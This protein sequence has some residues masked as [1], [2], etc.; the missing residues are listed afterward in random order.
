MRIVEINEFTQETLE[1]IRYLISLLTSEPIH[2]SETEFNELLSSDNSHLFFLLEN[3]NVAGM[4]TVGLYKSPTGSKA[5]IEDVVVE[6]AYRGKGYGRMLT[7]HA[8]DFAKSK[9]TDLI[10]LTSNSSRIAANKLYQT[11][12]FERKETNMYRMRID[13]KK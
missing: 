6:T 4:L 8:I 12:G 5:W 11:I 1:V 9:H 13:F 10:L 2:F 3:D 7:Q